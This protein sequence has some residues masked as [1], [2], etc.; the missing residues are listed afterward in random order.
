MGMFCEVK[1][2][3]QLPPGFEE[4]QGSTYQTKDLDDEPWRSMTTGQIGHNIEQFTITV[5]GKLIW[6][7]RVCKWVGPEPD[8]SIRH[9]W[10]IG[11]YETVRLIDK[12][13]PF[14]GDLNIYDIDCKR[15]I[16]C[17]L[18]FHFQQGKIVSAE[19]E[20]IKWKDPSK[21]EGLAWR[22]NHKR[23]NE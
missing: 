6:H 3:H 20:L 13:I 12:Q 17:D 8:E 19:A 21:G 11:H 16:T 1:C 2:E 5:D 14:D 23:E 9:K 15:R 22:G 18:E 10:D 4:W 7:E